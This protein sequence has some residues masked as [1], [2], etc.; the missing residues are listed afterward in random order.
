MSKPMGEY[1]LDSEWKWTGTLWDFVD[2]VQWAVAF[3]TIA[4]NHEPDGWKIVSNPDLVREYEDR[5]GITRRAVV[6]EMLRIAQDGANMFWAIDE[7]MR[8]DAG[9]S[10]NE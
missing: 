2:I 8:R 3:H 5:L 4:R 9:D 1:A 7:D 6:K 10:D